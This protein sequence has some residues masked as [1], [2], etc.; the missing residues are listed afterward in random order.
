MSSI[1]CPVT[2]CTYRKDCIGPDKDNRCPAK[3]GFRL[4]IIST[5]TPD[6]GSSGNLSRQEREKIK[7]VSGSIVE[8]RLGPDFK[9]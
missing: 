2:G 4:P 8:K 3:D 9:I 1:E 6:T 5:D 7:K